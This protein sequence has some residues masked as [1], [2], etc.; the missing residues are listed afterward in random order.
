MRFFSPRALLMV[1]PTYSCL[2]LSHQ[3]V[4]CLSDG[5]CRNASALCP[6]PVGSQPAG[7]ALDGTVAFIG[8]ESVSPT[9]AGARA[10]APQLSLSSQMTLCTAPLG[11]RC[12]DQTCR[13]LTSDCPTP[14][15]CPH[16]MALCPDGACTHSPELSCFERVWMRRV[17]AIAGP[18][19]LSATF[20]D[21]ADM[22]SRA[23]A[24][25]TCLATDSLP[26]A[27]LPLAER[28]LDCP[29]ERPIH[30][31]VTG[32]CLPTVLR[33]Q[34]PPAPT[35]PLPEIAPVLCWDAS[36]ATRLA[37]CPPLPPAL[38]GS[39]EPESS[40]RGL[41]IDEALQRAATLAGA[42][43]QLPS[44]ITALLRDH[45]LGA[46]SGSGNAMLAWSATTAGRAP[47]QYDVWVSTAMTSVATNPVASTIV[48]P[49]TEA[50]LVLLLAEHDR[51]LT[52]ARVSAGAI[53]AMRYANTTPSAVDA[54]L[55]ATAAD[56]IND[57]DDAAA[58]E[59]LPFASELFARLRCPDGSFAIVHA[60]TADLVDPVPGNVSATPS[61]SLNEAPLAPGA[62]WRFYAQHCPTAPTCPPARPVRC[63][64][65]S[66]ACVAHAALCVL[67]GS[68]YSVTA[69]RTLAQLLA[70]RASG[71]IDS[72]GLTE[73]TLLVEVAQQG[74]TG[75]FAYAGAAA[76]PTTALASVSEGS[77]RQMRL[78]AQLIH[79]AATGG[80]ACP[81]TRP[82]ACPGGG[83]ASDP[84]T[85]CPTPLTCPDEAPILCP[86]DWSCQVNVSS[87]PLASDDGA[88]PLDRPFHCPGS[89][90][91]V[92]DEGACPS[93]PTCPYGWI[94]W[95]VPLARV[96]HM[97]WAQVG[98]G[99]GGH[100]AGQSRAV[101]GSGT[102]TQHGSRRDVEHLKTGSESFSFVFSFLFFAPPPH[103][104]VAGTETVY[105]SC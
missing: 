29:P 53:A 4:H 101:E 23:A 42:A 76:F 10:P 75:T 17:S 15:T 25:T 102:P 34:C 54:V 99:P 33:A 36:C 97:E 59:A 73:A 85:Q 68:A 86:D 60:A 81:P 56:E 100:P 58:L 18:A 78:G 37:D 91:C 31:P 77:A 21:A 8:V 20:P 24:A 103:E 74:M 13:N 70:T 2:Y 7:N 55:L 27:P 84:S 79:V 51:V 62:L 45:W 105:I 63:A 80:W 65:A 48:G 14:S 26:I 72:S 28:V 57:K 88:C 12:P 41:T 89:A 5:S 93:V 104:M 92:T 32:A 94:K 46:N 39:L 52:A 35:C 69:N 43:M 44:V 66:R 11:V 40:L 95:S 19:A 6:V 1:F 30:C 71:G 90:L 50:E 9:A 47:W 67:P 16:D 96:N 61:L 38:E 87:C 98:A 49:G 3:A 83:C 82:Y 22:A 64:G